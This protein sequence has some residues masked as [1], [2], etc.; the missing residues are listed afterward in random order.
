MTNATAPALTPHTVTVSPLEK[1][2]EF[3]AMRS[4]RLTQERE[5]IVREIFAEHEHFDW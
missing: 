4:K 1:F 5:T 2:R 3:L